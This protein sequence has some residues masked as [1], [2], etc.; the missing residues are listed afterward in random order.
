MS[1]T[2]L[3]V[4][5]FLAAAL[6]SACAETP[7]PGTVPDAAAAAPPPPPPAALQVVSLPGPE[8]VTLRAVLALPA[9]G[10]GSRPPVVALH[11][12]GGIGGPLGP[13]ALPRRER[14]W[15][16]RLAALGHPVLFPDSFGSRGVT[17]VCRAGE[18]G[19]APET[20]RRADAHAAAAWAVTQPWAA[21][22][23]GA[24]VFLLGWS[25]G[26]STTL[27]AAQAPIPEAAPIRAAIAFYPG[28][29]RL[30]AS[31][32]PWSPAVPLLML[33]G[34]A[35]DWTP[36]RFCQAIAAR[37]GAPEGRLQIVAYPGAH[38]GFDHPNQ[39]IQTLGGLASPRDGR[40]HVG[41]DPAARA[42]VLARVPAFFAAHAGAPGPR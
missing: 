1:R 19:L 35:D 22:G 34:E 27:T 12:C 26:G 41:T 25:H 4:L 28:C 9:S 6:P 37:A 17:E 33:L 8:G 24:G 18:R 3:F 10:V 36:A 7:P 32:P 2:R 29:F 14:D 23:P 30:R 38:H 11:G 21:G 40:A 20:L 15:A 42:D 39:A 16:N 13:P 5:L 31:M